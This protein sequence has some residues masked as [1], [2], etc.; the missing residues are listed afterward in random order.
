MNLGMDTQSISR[1]PLGSLRATPSRVSASFLNPPSYELGRRNAIYSGANRRYFV[2]D[3]PGPIS[4]K[5]VI[6]GSAAWEIA[7]RRFV[8]HENSYLV[9]ND[10]QPYSM[11]ID[12]ASPATTFVVFFERGFV[13]DAHRAKTTSTAALLDV[14]AGVSSAPFVFRERLTPQPS[15]VL[16]ATRAFHRALTSGRISR[17]A[18]EEAFLNLAATL[19]REQLAA[20]AA[21]SRLPALRAATREELFRRVLRGRDFLLSSLAEPVSLAEAARAAC[22][23]R[24]HFL[25]AFR[26]VFGQTPHQFLTTQRLERAR[27]LLLRGDLSVTDVCLESGFQSLGS[28]SAL[29]R[30]HFGVSPRQVQSSPRA[31]FQT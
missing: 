26:D 6:S 4:I 1:T 30:R 25:R 23:S 12:S 7:G 11:T 28:F 17:T 31:K 8:V 9:L 20:N 5:T 16:D 2:P 19:A 10:H 13:E 24:F 29:F 18:A 14:P 15:R 22:L 3:F 27:Q 21:A